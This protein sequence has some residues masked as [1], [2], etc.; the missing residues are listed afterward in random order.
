MARLTMNITQLPRPCLVN[1]EECLFHAWENFMQPIEPSYLVCGHHGGQVAYTLGLVE[2]A[3]GTVHKV[4]P[5]A[6][7]FV[8]S[9]HEEVWSG[10]AY[11][12]ANKDR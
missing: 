8:D 7:K 6:I 4:Y 11:R 9:L 5:S 10:G 12:D 3:D 2:K 1:D